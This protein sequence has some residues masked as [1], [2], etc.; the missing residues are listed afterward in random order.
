[1]TLRER[2][3]PIALA[4]NVL[5][6]TSFCI[7]VPLLAV[8]GGFKLINVAIGSGIIL[9]TNLLF[10]AAGVFT[11]GLVPEKRI[12]FPLNVT[13]PIVFSAWGLVVAFLTWR[14]GNPLEPTLAVFR[15]FADLFQPW[16]IA[17]FPIAQMVAMT[18]PAAKKSKSSME[19]DGA[20]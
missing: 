20:V 5:V 15:E 16:E 7:L 8:H 17:L 4:S 12:V 18:F 10:V 19:G 9:T 3:R 2:Y 14:I 6:I 1:M 13:L 11:P